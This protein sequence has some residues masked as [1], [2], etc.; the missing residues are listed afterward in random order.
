MVYCG[1]VYDLPLDG[2]VTRARAYGY[3]ITPFD[4][5]KCEICGKEVGRYLEFLSL[6]CPGRCTG[7]SIFVGEEC[8]K[9][10]KE[11]Q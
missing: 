8:D 4:P 10:C 11:V 1:E 7:K 2:G 6:G 5:V 9:K 3:H